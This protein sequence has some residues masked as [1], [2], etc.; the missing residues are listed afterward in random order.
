MIWLN[1]SI[2]KN[3]YDK[4]GTWRIRNAQLFKQL[5]PVLLLWVRSV[6]VR[7]IAKGEQPPKEPQHPHFSLPGIC[8]TSAR[9]AGSAEQWETT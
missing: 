9:F 5:T 2:N 6:E 4:C 8:G 1:T 3:T 7:A